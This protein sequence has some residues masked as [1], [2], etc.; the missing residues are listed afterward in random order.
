MRKPDPGPFGETFFEASVRAMVAALFVNS[1]FGGWVESV[2]TFDTHRF[3][4]AAGIL[5]YLLRDA[6][7]PE[8][9]SLSDA[10][11]SPRSDS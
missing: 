1:P 11:V 4:L 9:H 7:A 8:L 6:S 3:F 2:L 5:Q 10:H